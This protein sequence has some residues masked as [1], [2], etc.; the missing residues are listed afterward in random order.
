MSYLFTT[1]HLFKLEYKL[2]MLRPYLVQSYTQLQNAYLMISIRLYL[3][4]QC[5]SFQMYR[6]II[7]VS[8]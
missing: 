8:Q 1:K 5:G 7:N 2:N 3:Q 6:C 4:S